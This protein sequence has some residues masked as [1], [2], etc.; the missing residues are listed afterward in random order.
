M[1]I[2]QTPQALVGATLG[3]ITSANSTVAGEESTSST[4][5][6]GLTTP[7]AVTLTTGTKVLV[8]LTAH[9]FNNTSTQ[10]NRMGVAVSGA[11]TIAASDGDSMWT[12]AQAFGR[13]SAGIYISGLTAGSNT[14]TAQFKTTGGT[15][16]VQL[17][18]LTVIDL[19]S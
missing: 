18:E 1:G 9:L 16:G 4:S 17:R 14:F 3:G 12:Y 2:S 10:Y 19:G 15:L 8:I 11:T 13:L 7:Q 5:F 6:T